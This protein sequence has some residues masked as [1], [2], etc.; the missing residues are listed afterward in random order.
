MQRH[1]ASL[2]P[3][4]SLKKERKYYVSSSSSSSSSSSYSQTCHLI[5]TL[6]SVGDG[7]T[8]AQPPPSSSRT[9]PSSSSSPPPSVRSRTR[10][11]HRGSSARLPAGTR[12]PLPPPSAAPRRLGGP[13]TR[14]GSRTFASPRRRTPRGIPW[15]RPPTTTTTSSMHR[16]RRRG[17]SSGTSC[18]CCCSSASPRAS[19]TSLASVAASRSL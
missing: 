8:Q 6:A 13:G 11:P 4:R 15:G 5:C 14:S 18:S 7:S 19:S 16:R 10:Q 1:S 2:S 17:S 9:P 3:K 12:T